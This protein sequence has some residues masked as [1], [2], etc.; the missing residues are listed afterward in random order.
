MGLVQ[1]PSLYAQATGPK[2]LNVYIGQ[3]E[4]MWAAKLDDPDFQDV[5]RRG[6]SPTMP[7]RST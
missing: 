3:R 4:K 2:K 7:S 5:F 6:S 1:H